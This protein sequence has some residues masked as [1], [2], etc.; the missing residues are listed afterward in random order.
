M[1]FGF[2]VGDAFL[3]TQLA[4]RTFQNS[5]K[6]C[7]EHDE[8]TCQLSTLHTV[9][10]RLVQEIEKA[11]SPINSPGYTSREE[12]EGMV[13]DCAS[14]LDILDKIL[15]KYVALSE[16]E[17][18]TRKLWKAV[19]FGNGEMADLGELRSKITFYTSA[20]TLYLNLV[21]MGATGRIERHMTE[22][23]GIIRDIQRAVNTIS[24]HMM[25]SGTH[26]GSVLTS[27][28]DDDRAVWREFRRDLI[29]EGFNSS[30]IHKHKSLIQAYVRELGSRGV[31]D[32]GLHDDVEGHSEARASDNVAR[33]AIQKS[34]ENYSSVY[35]I[36][37]DIVE[38]SEERRSRSAETLNLNESGPGPR[39][40]GAP[41]PERSTERFG[42]RSVVTNVRPSVCPH[43]VENEVTPVAAATKAVRSR[44]ETA[45]DV[46]HSPLNNVVELDRLSQLY[47]D[48]LLRQY[49]H[50]DSAKSH[51]KPD[52][53]GE[54]L[55]KELHLI[56]ARVDSLDAENLPDE[57][58]YR[59]QDLILK[60]GLMLCTMSKYISQP[61]KW[62][63]RWWLS[64]FSESLAHTFSME[65]EL[66]L[67]ESISKS[68]LVRYSSSLAQQQTTP[69]SRDGRLRPRSPM[70]VPPY[71]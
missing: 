47:Y 36:R 34:L 7:G 39:A 49:R 26:E 23:G 14:V 8:L 16:E 12:L 9:L 30:V 63:K 37:P 13:R 33:E 64:R 44:T 24:A 67:Y 41:R 40:A 50:W 68:V 22:S 48:Q 10:R 59:L 35:E 18:S 58:F 45:S 51:V 53:E 31:W 11:E 61:G 71:S 6:A 17:R 25:S 57:D 38:R 5:R 60:I 3:L 2:S 4:W 28:S 42:E 21:S 1:S 46:Q 29:G 19:K 66:P 54:S 32:V 69:W 65:G 70:R 55:I 43:P 20:I 56:K 52:Q 15:E 62:E 27:H